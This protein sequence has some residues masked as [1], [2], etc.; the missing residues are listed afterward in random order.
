[1]RQVQSS[2]FEFLKTDYKELILSSNERES[3]VISDVATYF[4]YKTFL[5]PDFRAEFGEDLRSYR[6]EFFDLITSLKLYLDCKDSKKLLISPIKTLL[7]RLPKPS[8]LQEIKL[9][10]AQRYP[11]IK[12]KEQL[13]YY[14]YEFVDIVEDR[15]EVAFKGDILDIFPINSEVAYRISTFDDEIEEIRELDISTQRRA[16]ED[17]ESIKIYPAFFALDCD[18]YEVLNRSCRESNLD[19]FIKDI[20][21]IGLWHLENLSI[22]YLT[23]FDYA[24]TFSAKDEVYEQILDDSKLICDAKIYRELEPINIVDLIKAHKNKKIT[25]LAKSQIAVKEFLDYPN[26][27]FIQSGSI[28]NLI[29]DSELIISLNKRVKSNKRKRFSLILDELKKGEYVVHEN[30]GI[31]IFDGIEQSKVLGA[32]R[33]CIV[34]RYQN[35]D[36]LLIPAQNLDIIDRYIADSGSLPTLDRLGKGNFAKLKAKAKEK[37]LEIANELVYLAAQRE[38]IEGIKIQSDFE[39][40]FILQND[41][42][43]EYT[44]DQKKAVEEIFEN[45]SSGKVMDRLL[46]GDVGFGKTEIAINSILATVKS[47]YQAGF[48]APTTLLVSQHYKS[49]KERLEKFDVRVAKLDR[50]TKSKAKVLK[51]LEDGDIDIVIAT[52]SL[53]GAKFNNLALL[54]IDEE[55]KFGVKQKEKLKELKS[56]AH[57]LSM[58]ATPIPRTLNLALSEIKTFS[59]LFTPPKERKGV[60]TF[61]KEYSSTVLKEIILRELRRDGQI[62]YIYNEI[63]TIENKK[64]E[65]LKILPNLKITILHSQISQSDSEELMEKFESGEFNM[66]LCTSIVESGIHLPKVNTIIIDGSDRFGIADLHQLR[67][68]VGRGDKEGFCYFLIEDRERITDDAKKRLVALESN[69]HLGSGANLALHDLSIRGGGNILGTA[70]SGHINGVGYSLYLKMLEESI[71]L[72][73]GKKLVNKEVDINIAVSAFLSEELISEDRLRVELYRRLSRCKSTYDVSEIEAEII[74]R[75]GKL[76]IYTKNFLELIVI[77][78]LAIDRDIKTIMNY[79]QNITFIYSDERKESIKADSKDEDDI[80]KAIFLYLRV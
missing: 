22:D 79:G 56:N 45:L 49:L 29:S 68:R 2:V 14:G 66:L 63:A 62:F 21:S 80:L 60:K 61:V 52:H 5:L 42:G 19:V 16:S 36:K 69:S 15:G 31:G 27:K 11:L 1:M 65:I 58:S 48:I 39:E 10:F 54:I 20:S 33:D 57:I 9:E 51:S 7:K 78:I 13:L 76:D 18:S 35:N 43:F 59:Q 12:L 73:S 55:H 70:Q 64:R 67:G 75:F 26:V 30:Y 17:L 38:L 40:I 3:E 6:D 8:L 32:I 53:L 25:L 24:Y 74:D 23:L 77:K 37:I 4:G 50:F 41:L 34:I 44:D 28:I 71:N 47:G 46:S 72:I